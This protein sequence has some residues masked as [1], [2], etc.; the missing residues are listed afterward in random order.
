MICSTGKAVKKIVK[1]FIKSDRELK[2]IC[3]E[4]RHM[5]IGLRE[6]ADNRGSDYELGREEVLA[7]TRKVKD[8][9]SRIRHIMKKRKLGGILAVVKNFKN[10][11]KSIYDLSDFL[12]GKGKDAMIKIS[13][14][15]VYVAVLALK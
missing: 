6:K 15:V 5:A 2:L 10:V 1:K 14:I 11:K 4:A 8:L 9:K 12:D 13:E 3:R 7:V